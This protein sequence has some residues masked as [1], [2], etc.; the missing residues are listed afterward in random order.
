[1]SSDVTGC[2]STAS[3]AVEIWLRPSITAKFHRVGLVSVLELQAAATRAAPMIDM[4]RM[5][6]PLCVCGLTRAYW[7]VTS[8]GHTTR[9]EVTYLLIR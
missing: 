8:I 2:A 6:L 7:N 3:P 5:D 1:M 9:P 4:N